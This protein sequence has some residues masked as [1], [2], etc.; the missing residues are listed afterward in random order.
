MGRGY[1]TAA[2]R[3]TMGYPMRGYIPMNI[4]QP[5]SANQYPIGKEKYKY[6]PKLISIPDEKNGMLFTDSY[7]RKLQNIE[8]PKNLDISEL[9]Y[10][11]MR[12]F[13]KNGMPIKTPMYITNLGERQY[14]AHSSNEEHI[15]YS[16][17]SSRD[18]IDKNLKDTIS[19]HNHPSVSASAFSG[20]DI[21]NFAAEQQFMSEV[22]PNQKSVNNIINNIVNNKQEILN[23]LNDLKGRE[24]Y[25][26]KWEMFTK[27]GKRVNGTQ[28][29][30]LKN[31][32]SKKI[33]DSAYEYVKTLEK[34]SD[35]KFVH[36]QLTNSKNM[37]KIF[38]NQTKIELKKAPKN[39]AE[40]LFYA[41]HNAYH[42]MVAK[43]D[44]VP[45]HVGTFI[46]NEM[47][48][49]TSLDK[50]LLGELALHIDTIA[51]NKIMADKYKYNFEIKY[52]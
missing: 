10:E 33:I 44:K 14:Y 47:I 22:R 50:S 35:N 24:S 29:Y 39:F 52:S 37:H 43:V 30:N 46:R 38:E 28:L 34:N 6:N 17:T 12:Y 7:G 4:R 25:S 1:V 21:V 5:I 41:Q 51:Q 2:V 26:H 3:R 8:F 13:D 19:V 11:V 9:P 40:P 20:A 45:N 23:T 27:D 31:N 42:K 48:K 18:F 15:V 49:N 36:Y 32:E 16:R